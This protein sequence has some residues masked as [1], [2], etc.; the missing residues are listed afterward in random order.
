MHDT[1]IDVLNQPMS[2]ETIQNR[3]KQNKKNKDIL[4]HNDGK[5]EHVGI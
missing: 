3:K 4:Q 2:K 5:T 1:K